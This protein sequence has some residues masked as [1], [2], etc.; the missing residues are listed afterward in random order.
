MPKIKVEITGEPKSG[1]TALAYA[2]DKFL[3]T[4]GLGSHFRDPELT[5]SSH[6]QMVYRCEGYLRDKRPEIEIETTGLNPPVPVDERRPL[7]VRR[8][9]LVP[10][11][12][13]QEALQIAMGRDSVWAAD[14][15][16]T[17][18]GVVLKNRFG[19]TTAERLELEARGAL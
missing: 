7:T 9:V 4:L 2:F 15:I 3:S 10:A 12:T 6:A 1:K 16:M 14:V 5:P 17:E 18:D 19:P 13:D 11:G 8:C